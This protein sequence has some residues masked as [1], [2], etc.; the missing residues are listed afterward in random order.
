M[1]GPVTAVT[2]SQTIELMLVACLDSPLTLLKYS[3]KEHALE[4]T[5][6]VTLELNAFTPTS[7]LL[8]HSLDFIQHTAIVATCQGHLLAYDLSPI[9]LTEFVPPEETPLRESVNIL[10]NQKEEY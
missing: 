10:R 4:I 6:L 5:R 7:L 3:K 2:L 8:T 9:I 1:G